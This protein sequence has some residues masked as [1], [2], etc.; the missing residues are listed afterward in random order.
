VAEFAQETLDAMGPGLL[1]DGGTIHQAQA[2]LDLS[3][4]VAGGS[5]Q[6]VRWPPFI[7]Q[8]TAQRFQH[9]PER[10]PT[11]I[12]AARLRQLVRPQRRMVL[13]QIMQR[14]FF[15]VAKPVVG[16]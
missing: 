15:I 6:R 13:P 9:R 3:A 10:A 7:A 1:D 12:E 11:H 16:G 4:F 8:L 2:C 14:L 5:R